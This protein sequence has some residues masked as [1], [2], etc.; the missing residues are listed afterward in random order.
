MWIGHMEG[1][2]PRFKLLRDCN[3]EVFAIAMPTS[4][5]KDSTRYLLHKVWINIVSVLAAKPA[6]CTATICSPLIDKADQ[7]R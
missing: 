6:L 2:Y 5:S 3:N 4:P 7:P 1:G